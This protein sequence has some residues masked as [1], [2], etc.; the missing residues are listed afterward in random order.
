MRHP[1]I[2]Q[3]GWLAAAGKA[4]TWFRQN[5]LGLSLAE[6]ARRL[7]PDFTPRKLGNIEAGHCESLTLGQMRDVLEKYRTSYQDVGA[8]AAGL[9]AA[10]RVGV[11]KKPDDAEP[12]T[13]ERVASDRALTYDSYRMAALIDYPQMSVS[14]ARLEPGY[15]TQ[16]GSFSGPHAGEEIIYV[17]AGQL[18]V[19]IQGEEPTM[20]NAGESIIFKSHADHWAEN[21]GDD[22]AEY[23]VI[24]TPAHAPTV[25]TK[26]VAS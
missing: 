15:S 16:G 3:A 10:R 8:L 11:L 18:D 21:P 6:I 7:G 26:I 22:S 25:A 24:R 14:R 5:T 4:L 1:A 23:L 12:D 20:L 13:M 19:H 9:T 17:E 2:E